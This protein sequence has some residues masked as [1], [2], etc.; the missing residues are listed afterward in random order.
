MVIHLC[1][2]YAIQNPCW[3]P[4]TSLILSALLVFKAHIIALDPQNVLAI[5]FSTPHFCNWFGVTCGNSSATDQHSRVTSLNLSDMGLLGTT[6]PHIENL[7]FLATFDI[8]RNN[9]FHGHLPGKLGQLS[10]LRILLC[11]DN[12]SQEWCLLDWA[13]FTQWSHYHLENNQLSGPNTIN[14]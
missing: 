3:W 2:C 10:R 1:S 7:S 8:I 13:V 14:Y 6:A 9:S 12:S 5:W 4:K 11:K